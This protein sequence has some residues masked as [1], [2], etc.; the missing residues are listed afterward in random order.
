MEHVEFGLA[1]AWAVLA[2][3]ATAPLR[4]PLDK[5][6]LSFLDACDRFADADKAPGTATDSGF[7]ERM[8]SSQPVL[9]KS[10]MA[11]TFLRAKLLETGRAR[12]RFAVELLAWLSAGVPAYAA[13]LACA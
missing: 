8:E 3:R 7:F 6:R 2:G 12:T 10:V 5:L 11:K 1:L 9:V 4:L 13:A